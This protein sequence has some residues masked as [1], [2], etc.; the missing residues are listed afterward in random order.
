MHVLMVSEYFPPHAKGG[1][2]LSALAL[3]QALVRQKVK[4][5]VLTSQFS[6]DKEQETLQGVTVYRRLSTGMNPDS[7]STNFKRLFITSSIKSQLPQLIDTLKPDVLHALSI[8]SMPGVAAVARKKRVPAIAHVNSPLAF[9][10]KGTLLDNGKER[11][12]PYTFGAYVASFMHSDSLGRMGNAWYLRYNPVFWTVQYRRWAAIRNS[13]SSFQHF[14]PISTAMQHWLHK[15]GVPQLKTTVLPNIVPV[16]ALK[17]PKNRVPVLLY[18]GGYVR[19]KGLQVVLDALKNVKESYKLE[20]V[21][22]GNEKALLAMQAKQNGVSAHFH[23][24]RSQEDEIL[25]L[26]VSDVLLFPS[27]IPEGLGR[28]AL[29]AMAAGKPVIASRIGGITD[30][31]VDGKTGYLIEPGN[32]AAWKSAIR[33]LLTDKKKRESFG[34]AGRERFVKEFSEASIVKKALEAYH[35]VTA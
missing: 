31:V 7:L 17:T 33:D 6:G 9:D 19:V 3:A 21:G 16:P 24:F 1:G 30:S 20:C 4:V 35:E 26:Q 10:P 22:N 11:T 8:T 12:E 23:D 32:V 25:R 15:Y 13:F 2:E 34:K 27:L 14:F 29:I 28:V 18:L 5:S